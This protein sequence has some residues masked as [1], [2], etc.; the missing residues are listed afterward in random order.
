MNEATY[1]SGDVFSFKACT[2]ECKRKKQQLDL[3]EMPS[4]QFVDVLIQLDEW[5]ECEG[6]KEEGRRERE[7]KCV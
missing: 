5:K 6:G 4:Q 7:I 1:Q 2:K 3:V